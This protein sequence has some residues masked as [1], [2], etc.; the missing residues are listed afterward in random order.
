MST[1]PISDRHY[2]PDPH[3]TILACYLV[4]IRI[5]RP[6]SSR[7]FRPTVRSRGRGTIVAGTTRRRRSRGRRRR[8]IR[9]PPALP[10]S[11]GR[12][13]V[14]GGRCGRRVRSRSRGIER[15]AGSVGAQAGTRSRRIERM[16]RSARAGRVSPGVVSASAGCRSRHT[17]VGSLTAPCVA[18]AATAAA[19][20][21]RGCPGAVAEA[22]ESR[23]LVARC[24]R[25]CSSARTAAV[26][27]SAAVIG[28]DCSRAV[29]PGGSW[30]AGARVRVAVPCWRAGRTCDVS[31][32][33][34]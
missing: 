13:R 26:C 10:P 9:P 21:T 22:V 1:L 32:E 23:C 28:V 31:A 17:A 27:S 20:C 11:T 14:D 30:R 33:R 19:V 16:R 34:L 6:T 25:R 7:C 12:R 2:H 5:P 24:P 3:P 15:R 8:G 18:A 29:A 4:I